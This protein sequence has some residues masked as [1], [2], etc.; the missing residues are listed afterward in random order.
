MLGLLKMLNI[1]LNKQS[2][3]C[4]PLFFGGGGLFDYF[5]LELA[6]YTNAFQ[7]VSLSGPTLFRQIINGARGVAS[8][9]VD[10]Y[11]IWKSLFNFDFPSKKIFLLKRQAHL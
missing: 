9:F 7:F 5:F 6:A 4:F 11:F 2:Y 10:R 1:D 8:Q 3:F